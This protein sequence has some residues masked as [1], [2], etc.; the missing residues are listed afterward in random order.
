MSKILYAAGT[1][2]HIRSFHLEYIEALR[3]CGHEVLVMAKGEEADF[4]I[5]FVKKMFSFGNLK[6][7]S[8]IRKI[9]KRERF[10]AI[11]LNTTLAAFNI[12][13][14]LPKKR[15][16][17]VINIVHG[18]MF[19][20]EPKG[21]KDKI[22]LFC[23]RLM[24]NKTDLVAVM[25]AEDFAITKKYKLCRGSVRMIM[26]MGAKVYPPVESIESIRQ[27]C[28]SE[29]KYVIAFVGELYSG[30]NQEF[31]IKTLP[32]V[33]EFIPNAVL[34]FIGDGVNR[35]EL[36][37]LTET[38]GVSDSVRFLGGRS[39]PCDFIRA[40][41]LYVSPSKKEGLP[42]NILEALG[43]GKTVLATDI[44]GNRD[45]LEDGTSGF[46][47]KSNDE[48]GYIE[49]VKKIYSGELNVDPRDAKNRFEIYSKEQVFEDTLSVMKELL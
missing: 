6:C 4:N 39:N 10:D 9:L 23:E 12:R 31:L 25:N 24:K 32:R 49:K 33:K 5:S 11:I 47:F 36:K 16:P 46:L 17:T 41:D 22:F 13:A 43:C 15:R 40:C 26:G 28:D 8:Q 45:L 44:K 2:S 19:P 21:I 18:Y 29:D 1:Y 30:K 7:Q 3:A 14:V 35:E 20:F 42:F 37:S 27:A 38:V 34:W 48:N